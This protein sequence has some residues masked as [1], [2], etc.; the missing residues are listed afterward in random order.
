MRILIIGKNGQI[1]WEL[2]R[3][4]AKSGECVAVDYPEIDL[5]NADSI[6]KTIA[7]AAPQ[8]MVNAAAY[9]A[10]DKAEDEYELA[11]KINGVAPG[12]M[13][14]EAKRRGAAFITYSTDYVYD[15]TKQGAWTE[16][17]KP[18]PV[19]AYGR[20]KLAGDEAVA[21]VGGAYLILRTSWVYGA[22]G[23]NFLLSMLNLADQ[24]KELRIVGDQ[25]GAPSWC[26]AMAEATAQ[27]VSS[28]V[29]KTGSVA[30]GIG[31]VAGTYCA[32]NAGQTSWAG[33]AKE[34]FR[35][36]GAA[37]KPAP[38]VI[39]IPASE[40]PTRAKRPANSVMSGE[41]LKETFGIEM[42]QWEQ[43]VGMVM[44][45]LGYRGM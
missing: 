38:R 44:Q 24:N 7:D 9:T 11:M 17:D 25:I 2:Q 30:G 32:T 21:A 12:I 42:P 41:K 8:L 14:E 6:R 4:L 29:R 22:R 28:A 18:N 33:F 5:V 20:T 31:E 39:E 43:S 37:G 16:E 1:G 23:K 19:N 36:Y 40:Y 10:V 45:E 3:S 27:T 26:R 35:C 15:G 13:A 34:I